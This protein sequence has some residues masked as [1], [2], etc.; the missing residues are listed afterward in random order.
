MAENTP[1]KPRKSASRKK[2]REQKSQKTSTVTP[3]DQAGT[4]QSQ[5][6]A[7]ESSTLTGSNETPTLSGSRQGPS[8]SGPSEPSDRS[9]SSPT[10]S[11][12]GAHPS[13]DQSGAAKSPSPITKNIGSSPSALNPGG[14]V[15]EGRQ[16]AGLRP[17][18]QELHERIR[19]RAYELFELRGRREGYDREDWAQ[20]EAE[21]L[22]EFEREKSA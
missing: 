20:A 16:A 4:G 11:Q 19:A 5:G 2:E 6:R 21:V 8:S 22:R 18:G 12:I 15:Q 10:A 7:K 14:S 3:I 17:S 1:G 13:A 9:A